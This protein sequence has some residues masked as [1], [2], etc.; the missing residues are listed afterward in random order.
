MFM[1]IKIF[2]FIVGGAFLLISSCGKHKEKSTVGEFEYYD[3]KQAL[4]NKQN[5]T[6]KELIE[7]KIE[8]AEKGN[9][10]A[11][12]ESVRPL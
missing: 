8:Y 5:F 11:Q 12:S 4:Q 6:T 10:H 7:L 3:A 9:A 2:I 1:K